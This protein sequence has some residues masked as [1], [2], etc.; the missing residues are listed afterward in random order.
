LNRRPSA[1]DPVIQLSLDK[2]ALNDAG[3]GLISAP[4]VNIQ[5]INTNAGPPDTVMD[6]GPNHVVQMVNSTLF[7][8]WDKQGNDL[9][10]GP[11][12]FGPLW[13][14]GDPCNSSLGDPIVVYDHLAD[15]WLLSQFA[16][17]AGQTRFWMCIAISQTPNPLPVNGYFLYTIE[18]PA[19]PDYPKFG[20]W[21]DAYYMSSNES[22]NLGIFAF[23]RPQMLNGAAAGFVKFTISA[24]NGTVRDTRIL[25]ADLDGPAPPNGTPNYFFRSVDDQQDLGNPVDRLE[26]FEFS[27]DWNNPGAATFNLVDT[28]TAASAT[29][30]VPFDTFLCDRSEAEATPPPNGPAPFRDCIPQPDSDDNIDA[31]SNRP[32]MQL[33][34]RNFNGDFRMV[35]NQTIDVRNSLPNTLNITPT[36]DVGGIRW[37]ELQKTGASWGIRQQGTFAPQ[38]IGAATELDLTHR[39]MGSAAMDR[40]G[41]IAV[42]YSVSNDSDDDGTFG[43]QPGNVAP[44]YPGIRY[45]GRRF[46]DP[47]NLMQQGEQVIF[48]GTRPQ[49]NLDG[50][51]NAQRWGDYAAMSIDPADDCTFWYSTHI[52]NPE[53]VSRT[54]IASFRFDGCSADL[55]ISKT[56]SPSPATAGQQLVYTITVTNNGPVTAPNVVVTDTLPALVT[57]VSDTD[58]CSGAAVLT[59]NLGNIA[60]GSSVSFQV[61]VSVSASAGGATLTNT[62]TVASDLGD[63]NP[64]NNTATRTTLVIE[65]ADLKITKVCKPDGPA[66]AGATGFCDIIVSNLGPSDAKNVVVVDQLTSNAPFQVTGYVTTP[67]V[68]CGPAT[69]TA[70]AAS[71]TVT[72]N[73]GTLSAGASTTIK[74]VVTTQNG[75]DVNDVATVSSSTP[76]PNTSNNQAQGMIQFLASANL[77]ITK[78]SSPTPVQAGTNLTYTLTVA[79]AGPS[80]ATNVVMTDTLPGQVSVVSVTPSVGSCSGG[81]PG[82]PAQ[83]VICDLGT[84]AAGGPAAI[85]TVVVKVNSSVP[86][87][88]I[89]INNGAVTSS[90]NDPVNANNVVTANS[91]VIARADLAIT[92]IVD[93][94]I[95]KS[96]KTVSYTLRA[97]NTG[98]SD[99]LSVVVTDTLPDNPHLT[100]LSDTGGCTI[101]GNILTCAVGNLTVGS[102]RQ[103]DI[104]IKVSGNQGTLTNTA[105]VT[106]STVDPNPV[107]DTASVDIS[108]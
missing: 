85:V 59:C 47:L 67:P 97:T 57:F 15:R 73:V 88:T 16:R 68:T 23:E 83:P 17:N 14:G 75:A 76:D 58:D 102:F 51:V 95:Y 69:P 20:V 98:P 29:P 31:L 90:V 60:S 87:G 49:G 63:P 45:T 91:P 86:D 56:A 1:V 9:S 21:P 44:I 105:T 89:L 81:I 78:T 35:V 41:N 84:L 18:V 70:L 38:P 77:S 94:P 13:P 103:F 25:P 36:E 62:A 24:L 79:N 72:C 27:V 48:N 6:V 104:K 10:G 42:G 55:S 61:L 3:I 7:Q 80:S 108:F 19:F 22:G 101:I 28:I 32:M 46:D 92:K 66:Q 107:N 50:T 4:D 26:V 40:F 2:A 52:G 11:L 12:N 53:P 96:N 34:F 99:A 54:R 93:N 100:Y 106:S 71:V 39:W 8:V 37:Y 74:V 64:D 65:Q 43:N 33:K 5:G 82:N 30:L